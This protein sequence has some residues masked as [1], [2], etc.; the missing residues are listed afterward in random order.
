M[1]D[2]EKAREKETR[3]MM[4]RWPEGTIKSLCLILCCVPKLFLEA[5]FTGERN[6]QQIRSKPWLCPQQHCESMLSLTLMASIY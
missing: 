3:E 6:F 4:R 1:S 5:A 2:Y